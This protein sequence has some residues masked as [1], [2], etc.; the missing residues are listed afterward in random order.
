MK[1]NKSDENQNISTEVDDYNNCVFSDKDDHNKIQENENEEN[2]YKEEGNDNLDNF[3]FEEDVFK[4]DSVVDE[5]QKLLDEILNHIEEENINDQNKSENNDLYEEGKDTSVSKALSS[6]L[7]VIPGKKKLYGNNN[8]FDALNLIPGGKN[9]KKY[10]YKRNSLKFEENII[11]RCRTISLKGETYP[12][13]FIYNN[14]ELEFDSNQGKD[15]QNKEDKESNILEA[16]GDI[17]DFVENFEDVEGSMRLTNGKYN[18][19]KFSPKYYKSGWKGG[20]RARIKTYD[21]SPIGKAGKIASKISGPIE[22]I[23]SSIKVYNAYKEDGGKIGDNTKM[24]VCEECGSIVGTIKGA[25]IG[26]RIGLIAGPFGGIIGGIIGGV[27]GSFVGEKLGEEGGK[28][29]IDKKEDKK[30]D[31]K[32]DKKEDK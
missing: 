16:V 12:K 5:N 32:E 23:N 4:I 28:L 20:S 22:L 25:S 6:I 29:L 30:E 15:N 13:N 31:E 3:Y 14:N 7:E 10:Q 1:D 17:V 18:G 11:K 27:I 19:D 8:I 21:L 24:T 26:A 9:M 2:K